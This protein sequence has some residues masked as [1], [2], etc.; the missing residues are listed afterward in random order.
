MET[1]SQRLQKCCA[2]SSRKS[3]LVVEDELL[4]RLIV[5][6]ELREAGHDVIEAFNADEALDVLNAR[7]CPDLV[8]SDVRMPGSLDGLG[9]L[10]IIRETHPE[11]PV[12]ITS[13]H[14]EPGLAEASGACRFLAKPYAIE[15]IIEAAE[16]ALATGR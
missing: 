12:I 11:L 3:I 14:L 15:L 6:D 8:I 10:A 7:A 13:G 1:S 5:C 4:I 2:D 16:S 9:L